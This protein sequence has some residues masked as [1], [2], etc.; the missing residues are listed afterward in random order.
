MPPVT[1]SEILRKLVPGACTQL[2]VARHLRPGYDN[3]RSLSPELEKYCKADVKRLKFR[4]E[5]GGGK[6]KECLMKHKEEMSVGCP[7]ALH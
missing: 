4:V 5:P 2:G 7:K 6:I 1:P 3:Y